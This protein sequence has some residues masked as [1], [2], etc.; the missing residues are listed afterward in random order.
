V[1]RLIVLPALVVGLF[2]SVAVLAQTPA[3]IDL[4]GN[5]KFFKGD[6]TAWAAPA[7]DDT[8]WKDI[9]VPGSWQEQGNPEVT[10]FAWYRKHVDLPAAW[11]NDPLVKQGKV[12]RLDLGTISDAY[13][14]YWN[15][16]V[17][18]KGG[19]L[20]TS[21]E[22]LEAATAEVHAGVPADKSVFGGDNVLAVRVFDRDAP[23]GILSGSLALRK[24]T[25]GDFITLDIETDKNRS[26]FTG[27]EGLPFDVVT[28]NDAP[29]NWESGTVKIPLLDGIGQPL[30]S[31]P[32]PVSV[33]SKKQVRTTVQLKQEE[34][35]PGLYTV[36]AEAVNAGQT[37]AATRR[38]FVYN[39]GGIRNRVFTTP[40][41]AKTFMDANDAF[42]K[43]TTAALANTPLNPT[44]TLAAD[45]ST[46][47]VKVY[48]VS[49]AALKGQPIHG[50]LV[51][52]SGASAT[53][54]VPGVVVFPG[55]GNGPVQPPV[56]LAQN[57]I[58]ALAINVHG[59]EVDAATYPSEIDTYGKGGFDDPN[60]IVLRGMVS[61]GLRAVEFLAQRPEVN[62]DRLGVV[63]ASQG[64]GLAVDVAALD[65]RVKTVVANSPAADFRRM[66]QTGRDN[67]VGKITDA[68]SPEQ[69]ET[70]LETMNH[71]DPVFLANRVRVPV[72]LT[73]GMRDTVTPPE[74]AYAL[75]NAFPEGLVVSI[76]ANEESGHTVTPEQANAGMNWLRKFLIG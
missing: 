6:N 13:E 31:S 3:S 66:V 57:G 49:Y 71:F 63:G 2:T 43:T 8:L 7:F 54:K 48:K 75:K 62:A 32:V 23:G 37:I 60:T 69:R 36:V 4:S 29:T 56:A 52:P 26:E 44:A 72:L 28:G 19:K 47:T 76:V 59:S 5:W 22:T 33:G 27:P 68:M 25:F 64:G 18:A 12:L 15:G 46:D 9:K 11:E 65:P 39:P 67:P 1:K 51:V 17:I 70:L 58:A 30:S 34:L 14:V 61:A 53:S 42:W 45:K 21:K 41:A 16:A 35:N 40:A 74:T 50:W 10:G 55:Y 73:I 38:S 20:P 24:P